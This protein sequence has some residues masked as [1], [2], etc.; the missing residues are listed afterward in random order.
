MS[1]TRHRADTKKKKRSSKSHSN[2]P[3]H[4]KGISLLFLIFL[5]MF[6]YS[7]YKLLKW[8][9]DN[10]KSEKINNNI[11]IETVKV[12]E[13]EN[14]ESKVKNFELE[15]DFEKLKAINNDVVGFIEITN[16]DVSYPIVQTENNNYYL[17]KD[18][19]KKHN[20][21]GSIFMSYYCNS[22]FNSQNTVLFGHNMKSGKM[23][24]VLNSI[25]NGK[26][27]SDF[28][29]NIY[30][31]TINIKYKP[32]A[33]YISEPIIDP[34]NNSFEDEQKFINSAI[35]KSAVDFNTNPTATGKILTLST[36]D[37]SGKKRTILHSI[38]YLEEIR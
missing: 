6:F 23:F 26:Y 32:F 5:I 9:I 37:S 30:T 11:K 10:K 21:C 16:T 34:I 13:K 29:I 7:G 18:I 38:K 33:V 12:K 15:I 31:P 17:D 4:S 24:A 27:G 28:D 3:K 8:G 2:S 19:Y 25:L 35:S 22:K 36:C 1:E 14:N 20:S